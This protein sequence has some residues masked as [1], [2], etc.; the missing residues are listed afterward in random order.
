L[1]FISHR[2]QKKQML[3]TLRA[4]V[5]P[6][7]R[8]NL[9]AATPRVSFAAAAPFHVQA[10]SKCIAAA[11]ALAAKSRA[12]PSSQQQLPRLASRRV[13]AAMA[14]ADTSTVQ[15]PSSEPPCTPAE[16]TKICTSVTAKTVPACLE[17]IK[18]AEAAGVDLIELR[19]DFIDGFDTSRDLLPL[20]QACGVPYI[21]TYRPVWEG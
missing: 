6:V 10:S 20:M 4:A 17:E 3:S 13:V 19:L 11:V 14:T 2:K 8:P 9:K 18:E 5:G 15:P 12:T 1:Q 21:V 7:H 16:R